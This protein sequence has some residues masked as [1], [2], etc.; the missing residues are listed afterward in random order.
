M[1]SQF[2]LSS[3]AYCIDCY[4]RRN[5][6]TTLT[7]VATS[8]HHFNTSSITELY[9]TK[10]KDQQL[11]PPVATFGNTHRR[12]QFELKPNFPSTRFSDPILHFLSKE[13]ECHAEQHDLSTDDTPQSPE[14]AIEIQRHLKIHETFLQVKNDRPIQS[15]I[16][17]K[18]ITCRFTYSHTVH[19]LVFHEN[20]FLV[21]KQYS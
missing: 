5:S 7:T 18:H 15:S 17:L 8:R 16:S 4:F 19:R 1:T 12:R 21:L 9:S 6:P 20:H 14:T 10:V 3:A 13:V 2:T 11:Q